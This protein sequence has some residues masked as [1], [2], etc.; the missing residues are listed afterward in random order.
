MPRTFS[1][2][3]VAVALL[4]LPACAQNV[5]VWSPPTPAALA[6]QPQAL[7]ALLAARGYTASAVST[8]ELLSPGMLTPARAALL[9]LPTRGVYPLEGIAPLQDY[10]RAGGAVLTLGG[11]PFSRILTRTRNGWQVAEVPENPPGQVHVLADFEDGLPAGITTNTGGELPMQ[12]EA[13]AEG[14]GHVLRATSSDLTHWDYAV[15][16]VPADIAADFTVLSFRARGD[17]A[18]SLLGIEANET[19]ASRWKYVVPLSPQWR[20][21]RLFL[22][23]FLSYA[24]ADRGSE[25]DYLHP[26]R[27]A[28]IAFGFARGMVG[29]GEHTIWLDDVQLWQFEPPDRGSVPR[30]TSAIAATVEAYSATQL[31]VPE[32][33]EEPLVRLFADAARFEKATLTATGG[34]GIL[35]P[36]QDLPGA[37]DG[38]TLQVPT[39]SGPAYD[40]V[41][42]AKQRTA[43]VT[44]VLEVRAGNATPGSPA[45]VVQVHGGELAGATIGCLALDAGN[46]LA[47]PLLARLVGELA[48]YLTRRPRIAALAPRFAIEDGRAVLRLVAQVAAPPGGCRAL[49]H[50][51]VEDLNGNLRPGTGPEEHALTLEPGEVRQFRSEAIDAADFDIRHYRGVA[52]V[53]RLSE[54]GEVVSD[55]DRAQFEVDTRS[56]MIELCDWFVRMQAEDGGISGV[57]FQDQ[58]AVRG[59][60]G[61]YELTGDRRYRQAAL[62]WGEH[63]LAIQREDGGYRMGYGVMANGEVCYVADG[64]EIAIGMIRLINYAPPER[65]QAYLD[66]LRAYYDF[67]ESFRLPDGTIAVGWVINDRYSTVGGDGR[68]EEPFRSDRSFS[69]VCTCTLAGAAAWQRVTGDPTDREMALRDARWYLRE[70]INAASVS[71]EAAQWAH[72]FLNDPEIRAGLEERMRETLP[73]WV[74]RNP[75]WWI[76]SGGRAAISL[77]AL[78]YFYTQIEP[79]P[80]ALVHIMDG[81]YH[82]VSPH[83][84]SSLDTVMARARPTHDEW[85][86]ACYA[87]ASLVEVLEPLVT[88]RGIGQ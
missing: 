47:E 21:Y 58:R 3:V 24:T 44:P 57:G 17:T 27:L 88:M 64:G 45:L 39:G 65:R 48:D 2:S 16:P 75:N 11:V 51:F 15:L 5:L 67:R 29:G 62:R 31:R 53:A 6:A 74:G 73:A 46:V 50:L 70:D 59:L 78:Q 76:A 14:D 26:E 13:V 80:E 84:P 1:A 81:V 23:H 63:E 60:L 25:G 35:E 10:L 20:E 32:A 71:G 86:Y 56:K 4:S 87:A 38:W 43:R 72:Y 34:A 7:V 52:A 8:D 36:R 41:A 22:P 79:A 37:W 66:S 19:D 54:D 30:D 85:R 68:R 42:M 33:Q 49:L 18:T 69:F 9:V 82:M 28:R 40:A 55:F 61:M 12:L 77:S 83:S